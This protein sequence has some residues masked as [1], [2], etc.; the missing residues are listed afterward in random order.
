[1]TVRRIMGAETE[2]GILAP[3]SPQANSTLLSTRAVTAYAALV[4]RELGSRADRT[5]DFDYSSETPLRDARGFEMS[6]AEAHPTQLTDVAPVLTSEEML[7]IL[8]NCRLPH[9]VQLEIEYEAGE[10]GGELDLLHGLASMFPQLAWLQIH[11]YR[12]ATR[13]DGDI[14]VVPSQMQAVLRKGE[15]DFVVSASTHSLWLEH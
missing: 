3:V 5:V 13:S 6:R 9:L 4:A 10:G 11:R 15:L 14:G 12:V 7:G 1:M 2:F 8:R